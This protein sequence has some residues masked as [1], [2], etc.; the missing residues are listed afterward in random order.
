ML[1]VFY[2]VTT[3]AGGMVMEHGNNGIKIE[4]EVS[5]SK[6]GRMEYFSIPNIQHFKVAI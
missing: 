2:L 4:S 5:L 6:S 1:Q 3:F